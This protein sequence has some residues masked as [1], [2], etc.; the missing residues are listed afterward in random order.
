MLELSCKELA[1]ISGGVKSADPR[2]TDYLKQ[3]KIVAEEMF[4]S[5]AGVVIGFS[6][7]DMITGRPMMD[8]SN[9]SSKEVTTL[10]IFSSEFTLMR[11]ACRYYFGARYC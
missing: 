8:I 10:F 9:F 3:V 4:V 1:V 2:R 5:F 11:A 6:V 7:L